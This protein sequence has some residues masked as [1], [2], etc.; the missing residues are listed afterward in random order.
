VCLAPGCMVRIWAW[1]IR[2]A[3]VATACDRLGSSHGGAE[4]EEKTAQVTVGATGAQR[5]ACALNAYG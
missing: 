3:L 4:E 5:S 1:I 2:C